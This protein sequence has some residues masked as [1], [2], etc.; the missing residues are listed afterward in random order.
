MYVFTKEED[1]AFVLISEL[2]R[3]YQKKLVFL[4][5][6]AESQ[7]ISL[8]FLRKIASKLKDHK[9]VGAVEGI[10]GGYYLSNNPNKFKVGDILKCFSSK[11]FFKCCLTKCQREKTCPTSSSWKKISREFLDKI[12]NLNLT[13]FINEK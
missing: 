2:A 1:Y 6:L 7:K 12:Y 5:Q 10:K 4:S 9:I 13:E 3:N 11:A 8:F